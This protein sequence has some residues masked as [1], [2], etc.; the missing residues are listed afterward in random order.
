MK[1]VVFL[2]SSVTYGAAAGGWS[3]C[4]YLQERGVCHAVKWAVSGTTLV[5]TGRESYIDRFR[6]AL[7]TQ[8]A[9][10]HFICQLSTNDATLHLPL[11]A[12]S[13]GF[14]VQGFDTSTVIGAIEWIIAPAKSTW[15]C[16]VSFYTGTRYESEQYAAMVQALDVLRKK[17]GIGVL[18]LYND[19]QMCAVSPDDYRRYMQDPIH[20][21]R[22]G[23]ALWWGPKFEAYLRNT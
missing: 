8:P 18:D 7:P 5:D 3:M 15:G 21:T 11:G 16:P 12:V 19:A 20:P 6:R 4:D 1:T 10:D 14:H 13:D 2:G 22:E 17:W 23:Y 9:C